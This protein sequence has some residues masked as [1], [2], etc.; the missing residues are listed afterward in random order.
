MK[1]I[2]SLLP[3]SVLIATRMLPVTSVSA[4]SG[5]IPEKKV[6]AELGKDRF[7]TNDLSTTLNQVANYVVGILII[8]AIFYIL[9]A[10]YD[11]VTSSGS[12]EKVNGARRKIMYAAIGVIVALL[13]KG[14]VALVLGASSAS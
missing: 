4:A 2:F 8:V 11:F 14:I 5:I 10:A 3:L 7:N 13:A 9:W 12:E 1:K 6:D